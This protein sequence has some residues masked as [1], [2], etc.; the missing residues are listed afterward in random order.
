MGCYE[1]HKTAVVYS[2]TTAVLCACK[3]AALVFI[4]IVKPDT[5]FIINAGDNT[6]R[7]VLGYKI[8]G[9]SYDLRK[10]TCQEGR[11]PEAFFGGE[12]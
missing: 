6:S 4:A 2:R 9:T 7:L 8:A 5:A 11:R 12:R 1:N 10:D 3:G